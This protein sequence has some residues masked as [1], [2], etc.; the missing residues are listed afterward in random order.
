M[1]WTF[2]DRYWHSVATKS[3]FRIQ[4][5]VFT[6]TSDETPPARNS[7]KIE[8]RTFDVRPA[9]NAFKAM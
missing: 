8:H 7:E 2:F 4:D 3:V 5:S 6:D 9:R 1:K